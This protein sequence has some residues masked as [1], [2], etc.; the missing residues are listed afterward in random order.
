MAS[1]IRNLKAKKS[2]GFDE[3]S[4]YLV[5]LS[6]HLIID[7][8]THIINISLSTGEVPTKMKLAKIVPVFKSG[9]HVTVS[10]YRPI[11]LLP[12]FS[13]ILER[14]MYNRLLHF[15]SSNNTL[16]KHQYGFRPNHSTFHPIIHFLKDCA[17]ANNKDISEHTLSLFCDLSKAF[18]VID[19][20]ILLRKLDNYGIRGIAQHW[21]DSYLHNR[22]QFVNIMNYDSKQLDVLCGVPQGSILGPLLFL[23]YINDI[24]F[25]SNASLLS[26]ADDTTM[27]LSSNS[28]KELFENANSSISSL[29]KWFCANQLYLNSKKTKYMLITPPQKRI[30]SKDLSLCIGDQV[31]ERVGNHMPEKNVKFLGITIDEHLTWKDHLKTMNSKISRVLFALKQTKNILPKSSLVCLYNA[32]IQPYLT[33]GIQIWGY[34]NPS[35][36]K[37]TEIIQKRAIRII[38]NASYN[39]HT[40]PLFKA[41]GLLKL[42]DLHEYHTILF[43][44]DYIHEN[45]PTSF[46]GIFTLNSERNMTHVT[47]QSSLMHVPKSKNVFV[48]KLPPCHYPKLWNS[49]KIKIECNLPRHMFK[50]A[51]KREMLSKY[52]SY[53]KCNYFGCK[54]CS[55]CAK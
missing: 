49:W 23:I 43:M 3:I 5:Q 18:D 42:V 14:I 45:L 25:S 44:Y 9:E 27:Y 11:S 53:V 29:Y 31:L 16:Y 33:Y 39:S 35:I 46:K 19:H 24:C 54:D 6:S 2:S 22:K 30:D 41:N 1:I 8:L 40:E 52:S 55:T 37:H 21:F 28:V 51:L 12:A 47:R 50:Y 26:F 4:C 48:S 34:A 17:S 32:L 13:K 20:D 10:N 38:N 36:L 15:L 7:P